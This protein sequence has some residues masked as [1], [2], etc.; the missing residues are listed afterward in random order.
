[1][2]GS[3]EIFGPILVVPYMETIINKKWDVNQ[4]AYHE[5]EQKFSREL[6][7]LPDDLKIKGAMQT[8]VRSR[9]IYSIPVYN[10]DF[11]IGGLFSNKK[12]VSLKKKDNIKIDWQ[13]VRISMV[14]SDMR[15]IENQPVLI[16]NNDELSFIAGSAM[17]LKGDGIHALVNQLQ[18]TEVDFYNFSFQISLRG[19]ESLQFLPTAKNTQVN[20]SSS[21]PHPSFI[22]S[23]LPSEHNISNSGF[24]AVWKISSLSSGVEALI[25]GCKISKCS[26]LMKNK[27]G[28]TLHQPVDIYHQTERSVKYAALLI[29]LTFAIFFLFEV[30]KSLQLHPMHYFLVGSAL[31]IYYLVLISLTEHISFLYAYIIATLSSVIIIGYYLSSVLKSYKRAMLVSLMLFTLYGMLY[32]ILKSEDNALLMGS[33]L[34]FSVLTVVMIITRKVDWFKVGDQI[35]IPTSF[36]AT[37]NDNRTD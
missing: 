1:W 26:G 35:A 19:M 32:M 23:Y 24:N 16:W 25:D 29:S 20:L 7:I 31:T 10:T 6:L 11:S 36:I 14:I 15:G 12:I 8:E 5:Y 33:I 21:W 3:Q 9:G 27:F 37:E 34:I 18:E 30:M 13:K 2:T 17:D 28:V 22:G 4:K